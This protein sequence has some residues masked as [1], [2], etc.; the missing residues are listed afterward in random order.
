[1]A[2]TA[3]RAGQLK[4][5]ARRGSMGVTC[6]RR[7]ERLK[8]RRGNHQIERAVEVLQAGGVVAFPTE[9]VYGLGCDAE[10][11]AAIKRI[12]AIKGRPAAHPLIVH[13]GDASDIA[14][15]STEVPPVA[16]RLAECFWPGP[17]TIILRRGARVPDT[18]TGGLPT[19][20]LRVPNHP[21]ARALL[22]AV[23]CGLAA[24]SANRFGAV[25]PTTAAHVRQDLG[26]AVD[27][28]LDGGPCTVGVEST[29][30]DLSSGA[31]AILRPGGVS[32]EH[33][34]EVLGERLPIREGGPVRSPGQFQYHYSPRA[35]VVL[36]EADELATQAEVLL[37]R[38][39]RVAVSTSE[40]M[41]GLPPEVEQ[42]PLPKA[43]E[44][45]ARALYAALREVDRR[46][47]DAVLVI[48]PP[49]RGLGL[50]V[51]DRLRRASR[52]GGSVAS[53]HP[54]SEGGGR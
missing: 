1:M 43:P 27:L 31:A 16:W 50:A 34:E 44:D 14:S 51:A 26:E 20:G 37:A 11:E 42:I 41:A 17:L 47:C 28:V 24:P 49:E 10:N 38:G 30:L 53:S 23:G 4:K 29:I 54:R 22:R 2:R 3:S 35:E 45:V 6:F 13:L 48:L 33:L 19:V 12:F 15:W 32:R 46:G 25:S 8:V 21:V 40:E 36:T 7:G 9:T 52:S 5:L 39:L 18:V